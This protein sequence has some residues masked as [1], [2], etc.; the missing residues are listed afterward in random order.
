[1]ATFIYLTDIFSVDQELP[2]AIFSVN[3]K[4]DNCYMNCCWF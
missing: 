4:V 2:L 3:Y 1:M